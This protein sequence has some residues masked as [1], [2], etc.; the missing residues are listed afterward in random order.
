MSTKIVPPAFISQS[1]EQLDKGYDPRV[2]RRLAAVLAACV[3]NG[4]TIVSNMGV[5]NPRAA[6][7]VAVELAK[8]MGLKVMAYLL[9]MAGVL[10]AVKRKIW[11]SVH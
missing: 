6:G 9:L 7:R 4:T 3:K 1:E 10:Y 5:A 8:R 2:E 11:S